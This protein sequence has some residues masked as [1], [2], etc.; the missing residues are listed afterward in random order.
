[1]QSP[2]A[3]KY[4]AFAFSICFNKN[5][6]K[7]DLKYSLTLTNFHRTNSLYQN[8][9]TALPSNHQTK[10]D[11]ITAYMMPIAVFQYSE[12]TL[13]CEVQSALAHK[14]RFCEQGPAGQQ[15]GSTY[16]ACDSGAC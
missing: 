5:C 15:V 1:M 7:A 9:P 11:G 6:L 14:L 2:F 3:L 12:Y 10:H 4:M 16:L 8:F 13:Q